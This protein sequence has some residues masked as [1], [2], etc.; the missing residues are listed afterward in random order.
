MHWSLHGKI[1]NLATEMQL[2]HF[3]EP[4]I[5]EKCS[6]I[7]L[8]QQHH[9]IDKWSLNQKT[10]GNHNRSRQHQFHKLKKKKKN[11]VKKGD[12]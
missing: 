12:C 5:V 4:N 9:R 6:K 1:I 10:T 7:V 11:A 2:V 3:I 8:Q